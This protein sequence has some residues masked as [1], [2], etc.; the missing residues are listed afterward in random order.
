MRIKL[1]TLFGLCAILVMLAIPKPAYA[2]CRD[3][4]EAFC[5]DYCGCGDAFNPTCDIP[6]SEWDCV[7]GCMYNIDDVCGEGGGP[8]CKADGVT[9][10]MNYPQECCSN[11]CNWQQALGMAIC[12]S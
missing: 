9:C 8:S 5:F 1:L 12:M 10:N 6:S 11:S 4:W 3:D 7:N 2:D